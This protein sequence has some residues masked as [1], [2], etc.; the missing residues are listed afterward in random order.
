MFGFGETPARTEEEEKQAVK[1]LR[2]RLSD[3][4]QPVEEQL[5]KGGEA[6]LQGLDEYTLDRW[7]SA[8]D[9]DIDKAEKRIRSHAEWREA[10]FPD[11]RVL[12]V[13]SRIISAVG[14]NMSFDA[15]LHPIYLGL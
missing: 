2:E 12:E 3:G 8:E 15:A 13:R 5:R 9:Y 1:T 4:S 14:C 10:E 6:G 7:L 11:G